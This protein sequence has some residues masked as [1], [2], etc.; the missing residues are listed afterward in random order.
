MAVPAGE[1]MDILSEGEPDMSQMDYDLEYNF[2]V[3]GKTEYVKYTYYTCTCMYMYI[4][5]TIILYTCTCMC[6]YVYIY[7]SCMLYQGFIGNWEG[8]GGGRGDWPPLIDPC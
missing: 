8:G 4:Y 7:H 6:M 1:E 5:S 2:R 3:R